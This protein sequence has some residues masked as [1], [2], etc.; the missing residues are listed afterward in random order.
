MFGVLKEQLEMEEWALSLVEYQKSQA[1]S[2]SQVLFRIPYFNVLMTDRTY[3][4]LQ[5]SENPT[6]NGFSEIQNE[7]TAYYTNDKRFLDDE[8]Q[9][10]RHDAYENEIN[11]V[12]SSKLE[13]SLSD[14]PML[15]HEIEQEMALIEL[16]QSLQGRNYIKEKHIRRKRMLKILGHTIEKAKDLILL[17]NTG[18]ELE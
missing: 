2:I 8:N 3:V 12:F 17:I 18:L 15:A 1:D 9:D 6:L 7:L 13:V 14:F 11:K 16:A 5:N 10:E 4:K